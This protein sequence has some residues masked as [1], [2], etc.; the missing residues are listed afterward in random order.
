MSRPLRLHARSPEGV[1]LDSPVAWLRAEDES[2]WFGVLPGCEDL[3]AVLPPGLLL[4]EDERGEGFLALS[5]GL[6]SLEAGACT[7]LVHDGRVAREVEA[8][9]SALG[10]LLQERRRRSEHR[11]GVLDD[12]DR[13]ALRRVARSLRGEGP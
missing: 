13:E 8:A 1:L 10:R 12:L 3:V 7:V 5:G 2:G 6:L 11:R 9:A 4:F